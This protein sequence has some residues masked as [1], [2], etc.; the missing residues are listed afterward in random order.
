MLLRKRSPF[1]HF[2]CKQ[3][4][5]FHIRASSLSSQSLAIMSYL[6][7]TLPCNRPSHFS[8]YLRTKEKKGKLFT[9]TGRD[10]RPGYEPLY[11]EFVLE[12]SHCIPIYIAIHRPSSRKA[13]YSA[14][15]RE[16]SKTLFLSP[17]ATTYPF[18]SNLR[19][20]LTIT[21][22][23]KQPSRAFAAQVSKFKV[24]WNKTGFS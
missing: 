9:V 12:K 1:N 5:T 18:F 6:T 10:S 23:T 24:L 14:S 17:Q 13:L 7:H 16:H 8:E 22:P 11:G 20:S 2:P 15:H 3:K 21:P 4:C 19:T